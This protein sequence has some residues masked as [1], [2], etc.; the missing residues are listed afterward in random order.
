MVDTEQREVAAGAAPEPREVEVELRGVRKVFDGV[1]AVDRIDLTIER[2]EVVGIV[3]P[4]GS[5]KTTTIRL[6]LGLYEPTEGEVRVHGRDPARFTRPERERI[7]YLPQHF[8]LYPDLT[9][10]ENLAFVAA[11]YGLGWLARRRRIP[12]L[13]D[14]LELSDARDRLAADLSGGMQ[15]RLAL[16]SA[17]LPDPS[18][19][20]LDEPTA[21]LDPV[22]RAKVW[23][24][25]RSLR[26]QGR[27][28]LVTTQYVTEAEYCDRVVLIVEGRVYASG[29]P[30]D[31]RRLAYGG[32]VVRVVV[33]DLDR[34]AVAAVQ[35][36]PGVRRTE[37]V[38]DS[39]LRVI[40]EQAAEAIPRIT[41]AIEAAGAE[42]ASIERRSEPFDDVFVR[43]VEKP[44]DVQAA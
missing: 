27:T 8:L 4:S 13:L 12:P 16:A 40:V 26:D 30:E 1:V 25:F 37:R 42:V 3:G 14:A 9:V 24:L 38:G 17:L 18:L 41:D 7:G 6:L 33:P 35:R 15:R 11:T 28:L 29:T 20:V 5:G 2:G 43:L 39:Q 34:A 10:R 21:G 22:L 31:L 32:E 36:V 19:L 44:S 23:D